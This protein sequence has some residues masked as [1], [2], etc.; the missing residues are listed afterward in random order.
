MNALRIAAFFAA[1]ALVPAA[2]FAA[3]VSPWA[4]SAEPIFTRIEGRLLPEGVVEALAQDRSGF[5]WIGTQGGLARYDGYRFKTYLPNPSDPTALPD[6]YIFALLPDRK[7]LWIGTDSGGLVRFDAASNAFHT[8]PA[9]ASGTRGP[10]S[11]TIYTLAKGPGGRV[12]IGGDAGLDSFDPQ[13]DAFH[14]MDLVP[15]A[16]RQPFVRRLFVDREG[17]LWVASDEGL[18]EESRNAT[19]F[20]RYDLAALPPHSQAVWAVYEDHEGRLWVGSDDDVFVLDRNRRVVKMFHAGNDA[21]SL[22]SGPEAAII[23]TTPGTMWIG[24]RD[25][26][27]SIVDAASGRVRRIASATANPNG[28][29]PGR[30]SQF[31]RDRSGLIW[32]ANHSGGLLLYNPL[33]RGTYVLSTDRSDLAIGDTGAVSL[34]FAFGRLWIGGSHGSLVSL[35]P[36]ATRSQRFVVPNG[37]IVSGLGATSDGTLWVGTLRGLC[38]LYAGQ[39]TVTCPAGPAALPRRAAIWGILQADHA[40]WIAS[41]Q[42]LYVKDVRSG[43]LTVYRRGSGPYGLTS[44]LV[45]LPY[46]DRRGRIWVG[47]SDGLNRIDPST[48]RVTRFVFD[49]HRSDTIGPGSVESILEDRRGR[50][51]AGMN[52]GP[53]NVLI[54]RPDGSLRV[55]HLDRSDGLPHQNVDGLAQ[56]AQGRIWTST[57]NGMAVIDPDTLRARALGL[58]DGVLGSDYWASSVTQSPDGTMF[59][60]ADGGV[61][62]VAPNAASVWGY[63]PPILLTALHVGGKRVPALALDQTRTPSVTLPANARGV[64]AEFAALDYS[65]PQALR[66][67]YRLDGYDSAWVVTDAAHRVATYTNLPPG[68][69]A[70]RVRA[71]NRLGVWSP[72]ELTLGIVALPAWYET[73]WFRGLSLL[74]LLGAAYGLVQLRTAALRRRAAELEA[75]VRDRTQALEEASLSDPLTGLRNRRFAMQMLGQDAALTLRRGD[76]LLFFMI[77]IDHFKAVNDAFGHHAGDLVLV[78]TCDR[79]REMFRESDY[80]VRWGGEE[81]LVVVRGSARREAEEIAARVVECIGSRPYALEGGKAVSVTASVGFAAFPFAPS[82]PNAVS[83]GHVIDV[84]DA[85]LYRAKESGRNAWCGLTAGPATDLQL[86]ATRLRSS[87]NGFVSDARVDV[88]T[89][90][91]GCKTG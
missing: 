32:I 82:D 52:G 29:T 37:S 53:L 69:Y 83:W 63:A 47:T 40:L 88:A 38:A 49:P 15:N 28:L 2:A 42:G 7:G 3:A 31:L 9:A 8:W 18:F 22:W 39:R 21:V 72:H 67:E 19:R 55:L 60:G 85:A 50:L 51:W 68:E 12:L 75:M 30:V 86:L 48:R 90:G 35:R 70:L 25:G 36:G 56:D 33:D 61:T 41:N 11:A 62:I 78:Q 79:L 58:A 57:D 17:T 71:T 13:Q 66:Y 46:R 10:R 54:Q 43:K 14:H 27:I 91:P 23:E 20:H 73:W 16:R 4:K 77:D 5:L 89:G 26:G 6:G 80:L 59:F 45:G 84:A 44:D 1:L 64:S 87:S 81:F 76:D 74:I 24:S 65:D 34:A